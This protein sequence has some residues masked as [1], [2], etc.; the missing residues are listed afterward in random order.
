MR[1]DKAA[2]AWD[3]ST[4]LAVVC[5]TLVRAVDGPVVAV[6]APGQELPGLPRGVE[7]VADP[8]PDLGPVQGLAAGLRAVAGRADLA[9]AA[10]T[11][12]PMLHPAV[13]RAVLRGLADRPEAD[14]AVPELGGHLQPLAAAYRPAVADALEAALRAD[15][16]RLRTVVAALSVRRLRAPDLLADAEVAAADPELASF[17][18]LNDPGQYA[19]ARDAHRG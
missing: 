4:L 16:R 10:A 2:L 7:V 9:F 14:V 3:G 6:R 15:E 5:S 12:L 11:D 19:R 17:T 18:N 8:A 1:Q 13:V